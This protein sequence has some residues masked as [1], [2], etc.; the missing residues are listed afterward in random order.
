MPQWE[1]IV[2]PPYKVVERIKGANTGEF[3]GV[4]P[5]AEDVCNEGG[6]TYYRGQNEGVMVAM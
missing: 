1:K 4:E 5:A 3:L 6:L 2:A